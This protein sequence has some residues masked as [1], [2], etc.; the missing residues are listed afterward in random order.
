MSLNLYPPRTILVYKACLSW[1]LTE[2]QKAVR[3]DV[4][5]GMTYAVTEVEKF[6]VKSKVN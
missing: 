5:D 3:K 2:R 4:L 6:P 1:G